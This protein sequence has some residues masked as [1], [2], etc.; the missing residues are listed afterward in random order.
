MVGNFDSVTAAPARTAATSVTKTGSQAPEAG[1]A[2]GN[3][4]PAGGTGLP[5]SPARV[6]PVDVEHAVERLTRIARES[7]RS[8]T[9]SVDGSSGRTIITVR[10]AATDEVVRQ[11]PS[12]EVLKVAQSL[13]S[14]GAM[15]DEF[16]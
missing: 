14:L 16:V 9:F 7:G 6:D 2:G 8:L 15:L 12:E 4:S 11:I 10:N 3:S 1:A 5:E 13:E